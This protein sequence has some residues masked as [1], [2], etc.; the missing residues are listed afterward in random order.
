MT[1]FDANVLKDALK[2]FEERCAEE[3]P[4]AIYCESL[5][6]A[7]YLCD[8]LGEMGYVWLENAAHRKPVIHQ[9]GHC[10]AR[11]TYFL[12]PWKKILTY[13]PCYDTCR[14]TPI[15]FEELY[16]IGTRVHYTISIDDLL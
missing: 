3:H 2:Q 15:T 9:D 12:R 16:K 13:R 11:Y 8:T 14:G 4:G 1:D 5:A 7:M 6:E 10:D